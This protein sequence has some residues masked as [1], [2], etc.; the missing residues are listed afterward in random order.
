MR[1]YDHQ[2][3]YQNHIVSL[4]IDWWWYYCM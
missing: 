2:Y 4:F 1:L 3:K